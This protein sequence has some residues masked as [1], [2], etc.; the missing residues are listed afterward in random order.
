MNKTYWRGHKYAKRPKNDALYPSKVM[1]H[2]PSPEE[3]YKTAQEANEFFDDSKRIGSGGIKTGS[4][5]L[6]FIDRASRLRLHDKFTETGK[7]TKEKQPEV[8]PNEYIGDGPKEQ[9]P[10]RV[11]VLPTNYC[12][13]C[14][15]VRTGGFRPYQYTDKRT[16]QHRETKALLNICPVLEAWP[17]VHLKPGDVIRH[18]ICGRCRHAN[19][20][21]HSRLQVVIQTETGPQTVPKSV[22]D[23]FQRTQRI[24]ENIERFL[25]HAWTTRQPG[26]FIDE[27]GKD[28]ANE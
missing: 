20:N 2:L 1:A 23:G 24:Q 21:N 15:S 6:R 19:E 12:P 14:D 17:E 8:S 13:D 9:K 7:I 22:F 28:M 4:V 3:A 25:M 11:C 26:T 5:G 16:K 18:V 27:D 10:L